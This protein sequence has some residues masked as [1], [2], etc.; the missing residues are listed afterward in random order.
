MSDKGM[1]GGNTGVR[2]VQP[3]GSWLIHGELPLR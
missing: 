1:G 2:G 3:A